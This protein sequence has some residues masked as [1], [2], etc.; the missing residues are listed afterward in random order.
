MEAHLRHAFVTADRLCRLGRL[1]AAEAIY[2]EI[3]KHAHDPLALHNLSVVLHRQGRREEALRYLS[4]AQHVNHLYPYLAA[5]LSEVLEEAADAAPVA[6]ADLMPLKLR[7]FGRFRE[8]AKC[9]AV[10]MLQA[11]AA[12]RPSA[13]LLRTMLGFLAD[14]ACAAQIGD[15]L[16]GPFNGQEIRRRIFADIVARTAPS[17]MFETGAFLG[18]TTAFMASLGVGHVFSCELHAYNQRYAAQRLRSVANATVVNLDSRAFLRRYLPCYCRDDRVVLFYLDAHWEQDLPLLDELALILAHVRRPI[19]MVDDFQVPD[20]PGYSFDDY[21]PDRRLTLDYLAPLAAT[22]RH[23]YFPTASG[24]ETGSRRGC[25][26]LT[27]DDQLAE[28]LAQ[29]ANLRALSGG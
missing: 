17:T 11:A 14:P 2:R 4:F 1:E 22:L 18:V 29:V 21:G 16:G 28:G 3:L 10:T 19:V 25:A 7:A 26:V 12:E 9:E 8:G 27:S 20:D 6:P 24:E 23:R 5:T 15:P 13:E